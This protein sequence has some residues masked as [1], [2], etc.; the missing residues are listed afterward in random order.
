MDLKDKLN[1]LGPSLGLS[2]KN[3]VKRP[4]S[5]LSAILPGEMVENEFG[6]FFLSQNTHLLQ[7]NVYT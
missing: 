7:K 4:L 5:D 2:E 3:K 6:Q 1:L